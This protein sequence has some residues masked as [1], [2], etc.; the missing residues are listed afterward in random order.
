MPSAE[1]T[2]LID[3]W[4][5]DPKFREA[6]RKDPEGTVR[7]AGAELTQEEWRALR[8]VDWTM[9]DEELGARRTSPAV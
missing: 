3:R 8:N 4:M 1:V 2:K 6:V 7:K 5:K 9:T